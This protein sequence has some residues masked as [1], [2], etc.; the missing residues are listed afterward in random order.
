MSE[1]TIDEMLAFL[2][3]LDGEVRDGVAFDIHRLEFI[4]LTAAIRAILEQHRDGLCFSKMKWQDEDLRKAVQE[5]RVECIR[6]FVERVMVRL[7]GAY[8]SVPDPKLGELLMGA[9]RDEV[10]EMEKGAK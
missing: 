1:P 5:S 3:N 8:G 9:I 7:S 4:T 10:D 6:A 2:N